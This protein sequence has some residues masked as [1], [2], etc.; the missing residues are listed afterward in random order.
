MTTK[1]FDWCDYL[2]FAIDM[3]DTQIEDESR[4]RAAIS[5][6]Y[7]A[8]F[9]VA[10]QFAESQDVHIDT[11][12]KGG[13]ARVW[14]AYTQDNPLSDDLKFLTTVGHRLKRLRV[15]ADYEGDAR[16]GQ[17]ELKRGISEAEKII[18]KLKS[19]LD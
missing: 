5:R 17:S 6:A 2:A 1:T 4:R 10:K 15:R 3:R 14:D 11:F 9:N 12:G 19:T 8:A 13:H 16:V 18:N 7:Y